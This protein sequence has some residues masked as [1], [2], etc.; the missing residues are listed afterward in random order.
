MRLE[1]LRSKEARRVSSS[2]VADYTTFSQRHG[3]QE[4][5]NELRVFERFFA[6]R[7][8]VS[9]GMDTYL[10]ATVS[11][12][13]DHSTIRVDTCGVKDGS[14]ILVFCETGI[15][16]LALPGAIEKVNRSQNAQALILAPPVVDFG[17]L[18]ESAV[19]AFQSGKVKLETLGWFDDYFD[20]TLQQTLR[21]IGLLGN[22][23]RM[24]MLA[25]LFQRAGAK[26]DYRSRINPKLVYKNLSVMVDAGLVDEIPGGNY[27]LSLF[28]KSILAEFITFLEKA[29][30]TL[31]S[32]SRGGKEVSVNE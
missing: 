26:K 11:D 32:V 12:T 15:P 19:A 29:R 10:D 17:S 20:E 6:A 8:L 9:E 13:E 23:T 14:L 7:S 31:Y 3:A 28:G 1:I 5:I 27:E 16:S 25:P 21:L 24:R 4:A 2:D 22:E 18:K 30:K